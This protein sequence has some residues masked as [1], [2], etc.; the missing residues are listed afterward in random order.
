MSNRPFYLRL[1]YVLLYLGGDSF[2]G[3]KLEIGGIILSAV[4][5][6]SLISE[7]HSRSNCKFPVWSHPSMSDEAT[8]EVKWIQNF[9]GQI[10]PTTAP[11][12]KATPFHLQK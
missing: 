5:I 7:T 8:C 1:L 6:S 11:D 9:G 2:R 12:E 4:F 3:R 10:K